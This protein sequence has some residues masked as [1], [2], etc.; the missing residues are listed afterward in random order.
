MLAPLKF[1]VFNLL[2]PSPSA[3]IDEYLGA[4]DPNNITFSLSITNQYVTATTVPARLNIVGGVPSY[5][6]LLIND[7]NVTWQPFTTTNLSIST[8]T[9]GAYAVS[10]GLRGL[11]TNAAQTWH[12]VTLTRDTTPLTLA[13]TNLA[14]RTGSRPFIDPAGYATRS[15]SAIT[16]TVVDATGTTNHGSGIVVAQGWNLLDPY[17]TTNWFQCLDLALALGTNWISIQATDWAGTVAVTNFAYVFNTNGD[18]TPPAFSLLWP[19]DGSLISG[20]TLTLPFFSPFGA[21]QGKRE[22]GEEEKAGQGKPCPYERQQ[23]KKKYL[24]LSLT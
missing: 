15:L 17:H 16:W 18:T 12:S 24:W 5:I 14:L 23:Q 20:D 9:N 4:T 3:S 22:R 21:A 10:V 19:Q 13:L 11:P 7:T 1:D 8:P 2:C 6:A